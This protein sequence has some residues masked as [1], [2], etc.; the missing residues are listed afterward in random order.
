MSGPLVIRDGIVIPESE[1]TWHAVR[2]SGPGGQN[3]NKVSTKVVLVFDFERS[4]LLSDAARAR[5]RG[6]AGRYL[7][8]EGRLAIKSDKTR[9]QL[10]NLAD[11][12]E[13]LRACVEEALREP[14]RR[15][16]TRRTRGSNER[17]LEG[18]RVVS[19]KK[20]ERSGRGDEG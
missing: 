18:K 16:P 6:L 10:K 13:K 3:V 9:D 7:D 4:P 1:L 2:S 14:K 15:R 17:R 12:G 5:L 19:T 11:A 20:R 8:A